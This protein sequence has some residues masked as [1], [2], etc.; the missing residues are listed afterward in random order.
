MGTWEFTV[1]VSVLFSG[2][3]FSI[4]KVLKE[5]GKKKEKEKWQFAWNGRKRKKGEILIQ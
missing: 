4:V 1:Q 2:L 3:K 5:S